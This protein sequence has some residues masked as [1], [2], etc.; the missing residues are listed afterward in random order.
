MLY[1]TVTLLVPIIS[2]KWVG[3]MQVLATKEP[4][5]TPKTQYFENIKQEIPK[6]YMQSTLK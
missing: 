5:F 1:Y 2:A 3:E 6:F 4:Y